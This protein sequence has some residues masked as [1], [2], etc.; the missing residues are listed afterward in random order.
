MTRMRL[1]QGF[2]NRVAELKTDKRAKTMKP[3]G[4]SLPEDRY[5]RLREQGLC[6]GCAKAKT[7]QAYCE[8]CKAITLAKFLSKAAANGVDPKQL[9]RFRYDFTGSGPLGWP[10]NKLKMKKR[11]V[12]WQ[13]IYDRWRTDAKTQEDKANR[14][15]G[16]NAD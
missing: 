9:D 16:Q 10:H 15:D 12:T 6:R 7:K 14:H 13:Q 11:Q 4:T 8:D 2:A 5:R 1:H 3:R